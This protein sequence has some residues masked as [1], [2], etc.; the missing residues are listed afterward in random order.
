LN[1]NDEDKLVAEIEADIKKRA[2]L[3]E[4][5]QTHVTAIIREELERQ[6][7]DG[8]RMK[9][10]KGPE[11]YDY[12]VRPL[13]LALVAIAAINLL[14][15]KTKSFAIK[16]R[17]VL[18]RCLLNTDIPIGS[19]GTVMSYPEGDEITVE[20]DTMKVWVPVTHLD[21]VNSDNSVADDFVASTKFWDAWNVR[22][23]EIEAKWN[24]LPWYKKI[25][26]SSEIDFKIE[27][28]FEKFLIWRRS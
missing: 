3:L 18:T 15:G 20:F 4:I 14:R 16:D 17:V 21:K 2:S 9:H 26:R 13:Q 23:A 27:A 1:K 8:D 7:R 6:D 24:A 5:E 22:R 19:I 11:Y 10:Y 28:E 25:F 12:H